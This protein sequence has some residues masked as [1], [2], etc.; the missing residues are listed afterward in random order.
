[1]A[2]LTAT[3]SFHISD[4][5]WMTKLPT[6]LPPCH[7]SQT[8]NGWLRMFPQPISSSTTTTNDSHNTTTTTTTTTTTPRQ[9]HLP[10]PKDDRPAAGVDRRPRH[11]MGQRKGQRRGAARRAGR[12]TRA[13]GA[14]RRLRGLVEGPN[15]AG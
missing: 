10:D 4:G 8:R 9:C 12:A 5:N 6:D 15:R 13:T 3:L 14:V 7:I 11:R 1:M 2:D